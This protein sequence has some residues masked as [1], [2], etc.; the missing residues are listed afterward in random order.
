[1]AGYQKP[2]PEDTA[3]ICRNGHVVLSSLEE[4]PQFQKSYCEECG[5]PTMSACDKCGWPIAGPSPHAWMAE[6]GPYRPPRFCGECGTPFP[7]T[8]TALAS[9]RKYTDSL[10]SLDEDEKQSLKTTID[11]LTIDSPRTPVAA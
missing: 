5:S 7:W 2:K 6:R 9:A 4:F 8:Q 3:Q 10:E 1:M 11:E